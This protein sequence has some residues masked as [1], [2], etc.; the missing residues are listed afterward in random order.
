M[1]LW[2]QYVVFINVPYSLSQ[3]LNGIIHLGMIGTA[4]EIGKMY[5]MSVL[6]NS[7]LCWKEIKCKF[8]LKYEWLQER[9]HAGGFLSNLCP[10]CIAFSCFSSPASF[11]QGNRKCLWLISCVTASHPGVPT[12]NR[13]GQQIQITLTANQLLFISLPFKV[14]ESFG[15]FVVGGFFK[16]KVKRSKKGT[17]QQE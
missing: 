12:H 14:L 3:E 1:W 10:I 6:A 7:Q 17:N 11:G 13:R 9:Q 15:G 8:V 2:C 4:C 16:V 5:C